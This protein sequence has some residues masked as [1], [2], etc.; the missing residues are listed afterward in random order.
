MELDH[1]WHLIRASAGNSFLWDTCGPNI[2]RGDFHDSFALDLACKDIR[3]FAEMAKD[4]NVSIGFRKDLLIKKGIKK[5]TKRI[6]GE[7]LRVSNR[8]SNGRF[9]D[10][11]AAGTGHSARQL[12]LHGQR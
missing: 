12:A 10:I 7:T 9:F 6:K 2:F 11:R 5:A 1:F 8:A 4:V 3:L